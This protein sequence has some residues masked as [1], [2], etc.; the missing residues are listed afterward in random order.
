[1]MLDSTNFVR[2]WDKLPDELKLAVLRHALQHDRPLR[3]RSFVQHKRYELSTSESI[4]DAAHLG[5]E[6]ELEPE[7]ESSY[8]KTTV[9]PFLACPTIAQLAHEAFCTQNRFMLEPHINLLPPLS[10]RNL[11]R[12]M[13]LDVKATVSEIDWLLQVAATSHSFTNL[14]LIEIT[15]RGSFRDMPETISTMLSKHSPIGFKTKRLVIR[16]RHDCSGAPWP[17]RLLDSLEMD[18]MSAF[19]VVAYEGRKP[20]ERLERRERKDG[21][22][23]LLEE[24]HSWP[25]GVQDDFGIR[26]TTK[27]VWI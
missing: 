19:S 27:L 15:V 4:W 18:Y 23:R 13:E 3:A 8:F 22:V 9:L 21:T 16:Y 1:M 20:Q 25:A 11:I 14:H 10:A 26:E 24:G 17:I 2:G 7:P 6:L 12:H 5:I